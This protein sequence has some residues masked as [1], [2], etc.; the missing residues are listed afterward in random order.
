VP[1][2]DLPLPELRAY[3]PDLPAPADLD[4]FWSTTLAEARTHDL[5]AT[6]APVDSGLTRPRRWVSIFSYRP[7]GRGHAVRPAR[8][9]ST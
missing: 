5:A 3:A 1:H 9:R 6:F 8:G 2:Y 7:G 4:E